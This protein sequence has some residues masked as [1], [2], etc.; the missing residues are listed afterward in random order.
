MTDRVFVISEVLDMGCEAWHRAEDGAV[1]LFHGCWALRADRE[2]GTR[3]LVMDLTLVPEGP[4]RL[5]D[6]GRLEF[7]R[8]NEGADE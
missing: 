8:L 1:W 6:W 5:T 4:W 7:A 3:T 2:R